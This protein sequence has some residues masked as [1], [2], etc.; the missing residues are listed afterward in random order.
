MGDYSG[1]GEV[2]ISDIDQIR[3]EMSRQSSTTDTF[4]ETCNRVRD[5]VSF[6]MM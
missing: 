3:A 6:D 4:R 1:L 5:I 2:Q